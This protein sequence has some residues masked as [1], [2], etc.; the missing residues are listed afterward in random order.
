LTIDACRAIPPGADSPDAILD[1][2]NLRHFVTHGYQSESFSVAR[3]LQIEANIP[4]T[5][6]G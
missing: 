1:K 2:L 6:G 5:P 3:H 4:N